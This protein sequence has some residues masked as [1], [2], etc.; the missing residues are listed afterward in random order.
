MNPPELC[1]ELR[2]YP[3]CRVRTCLIRSCFKFAPV[4][5]RRL[6]GT[7]PPHVK[8]RNAS[9]LQTSLA[10]T[11]CLVSL[12][13]SYAP[14]SQF[15]PHLTYIV[16]QSFLSFVG[17]TSDRFMRILLISLAVSSAYIRMS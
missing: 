4:K 14:L 2:E 16:I 3:T 7:G 17:L 1:G 11:V 6:S 10:S 13:A 9:S 12:S 8:H 15:C 5:T